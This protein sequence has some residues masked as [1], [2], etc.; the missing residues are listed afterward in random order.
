M[1]RLALVA[2]VFALAC[3]S[4]NDDPATPKVD[5][6]AD[7]AAPEPAV[8]FLMDGKEAVRAFWGDP[9]TIEVT[10]MPPGSSVT[11][12]ARADIVN[13]EAESWATYTADASGTVN[14][15]TTSAVDG[16]YTGVEPEGLVWS[17]T[18]ATDTADELAFDDFRVRVES[19]GATVAEGTLGR[20]YLA[21][22]VTQMDVVESGLVGAFYA[23]PGGA[24]PTLIT[25]GGSEGGLT[26]GQTLAWYYASLGYSVLALAYFN[27]PGLPQYLTQ[28]P[29]E[30]FDTARQWLET[31]PEADTT[32]IAVMGGSR[33]G[34]LAL[35][36]G[37]TFPWV[38]AVIASVPSG[39]SWGA[40]QLG[41]T[42]VSSWTYQSQGLAFVPFDWTAQPTFTQDADGVEL[43]HDRAL[44]ESSIAKATPTKLDL[45]SFR[46]EQTQGPILMI[47]GADD[48]LWPSCQLAQIAWDRLEKSG[49]VDKYG[50]ELVCAPDA[51]HFSPVVGSPTVGLHRAYHPITK[52]WLALGGTPA[53]TAHAKRNADTK[54]R[55]LLQKALASP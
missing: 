40:P 55:A 46:V 37:A 5:G 35:A 51:G 7:A 53:G 9:V 14:V 16:S 43:E 19:E 41:N 48:Q 6:G 34:E 15:D 2:G 36:L 11:L 54:I 33:G 13:Q 10:G 26:G 20:Y 52:Q 23:P 17:M 30:Y 44:F 50:D 3:S 22:D 18:P 4:S 28:V 32:R 12:R 38:K 27:V 39:V 29:L 25:F 1:R 49:H 21:D 47:A 8:R 24:H 31:R 45:A 42:E